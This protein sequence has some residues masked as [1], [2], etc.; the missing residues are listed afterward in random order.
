MINYKHFIKNCNYENVFDN[1][2]F[3]MY[4]PY[5][6]MPMVKLFTHLKYL[7]VLKLFRN[8]YIF[9]LIIY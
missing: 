5:G 3:K 9:N 7:P 6:E 2:N 8:I 4:N 1:D